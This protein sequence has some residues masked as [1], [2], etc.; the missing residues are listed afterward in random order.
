MRPTAAPIICPV[1]KYKSPANFVISFVER[2]GRDQPVA[3]H[4]VATYPSLGLHINGDFII[5]DADLWAK[6]CLKDF[7]S[8]A[9]SSQLSGALMAR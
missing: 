4:I 2:R 5:H 3:L 9:V 7:L 1:R 6:I 8:T